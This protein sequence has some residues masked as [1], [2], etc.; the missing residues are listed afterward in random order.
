MF[1]W[2]LALCGVT[3]AIVATVI[4]SLMDR[5]RS[6]YA[7]LDRWL[8]LYVRLSLAYT[9]M[10]YGGVK[11]IP[12]QFPQPP[13]SWLLQPYGESSP[14]R[15]LWTFMGASPSYVVITGCVEL[16]A[17]ILLIL[18]R[19]AM[20]GAIVSAAAM[21]QVF[22][23][24]LCYDVPVKLYSFHLIL[25]SVFLLIPHFRR[26][27]DFLANRMAQPA[28]IPPLFERRLL[29]RAALVIQVAFGIYMAGS[30]MYSGYQA[31]T[32]YG[33]G[34]PKA[35]LYGIWSVEEVAVNG[36]IR[37]PLLTDQTR[38]R[39][40]VFQRPGFLVVQPMSG[41]NQ[42]YKLELDVENKKMALTKADDQEWKA[43][44]FLE[45]PEQ[46][47]ITLDGHLEGKPIRAKLLRVDESQF[48]LKSRGF[49]WV[50]EVPFNR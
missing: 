42:I 25:L 13:L 27:A 21:T 29:N 19:T 33:A 17:G 43:D 30:S 9:M 14:M 1:D 20:L 12:A 16:L 41:P 23:L 35:P 48:L 22:V 36:E 5:S 45:Q 50:S 6:D 38:W 7:R 46:G 49:H 3:I 31:Y 32:T 4:W 28:A 11:L 2:I 15:L 37:P 47:V 34:A 26:I 39:R 24:N 8:R 44:F 40:L 10:S 18:P